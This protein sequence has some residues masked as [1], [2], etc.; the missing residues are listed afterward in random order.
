VSR[1]PEIDLR[2]VKTISVGKRP[3][4]VRI[5]QFAPVPDPSAPIGTFEQFLPDLLAGAAL[6]ELLQAWVVARADG[7]PAIA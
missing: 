3:N 2:S 1:H 5:E 6:R 7:R 4:K